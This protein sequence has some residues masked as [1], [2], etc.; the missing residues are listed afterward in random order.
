MNSKLPSSSRISL[1]SLRLLFS[2]VLWASLLDVPSSD[3]SIELGIRIAWG[4]LKATRKLSDSTGGELRVQYFLHKWSIYIFCNQLGLL[5]WA[6]GSHQ[7]SSSLLGQNLNQ[8]RFSCSLGGTQLTPW[9]KSKAG[10]FLTPFLL[11][12]QVPYTLPRKC[13]SNLVTSILP[14]TVQAVSSLWSLNCLPASSPSWSCT[15]E[16]F[17]LK[18]LFIYFW[19]CWVFVSV[20]GLSP[21]AEG[22]GHSSLRC[23]GLSLSRPLLLWSTGSRRAGS[24]V[25]AHGLSCSAACGT[26]PDQGSNPCPLHWQAD[27]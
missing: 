1:W 12:R 4:N 27:S 6:L 26:F 16:S 2:T 21:V 17:F 10:V 14:A 23:A 7:G 24:V 18:K 15:T 11:L 9:S 13:L 8:I 5:R 3:S 25:V 22:G 20:R 19:L